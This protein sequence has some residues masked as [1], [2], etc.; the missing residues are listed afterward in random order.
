MTVCGLF[1]R[2][3]NRDW[4]SKNL[5]ENFVSNWHGLPLRKINERFSFLS[6]KFRFFVCLSVL[7]ENCLFDVCLLLDPLSAR[8]EMKKLVSWVWSPIHYQSNHACY[9]AN[10]DSEWEFISGDLSCMESSTLLR[11]IL[12]ACLLFFLN[13]MLYARNCNK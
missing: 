12:M 10:L 11:I 6:G 2:Q 7:Q 5:V 4:S 3:R 1:L 8:K 9:M 13:H